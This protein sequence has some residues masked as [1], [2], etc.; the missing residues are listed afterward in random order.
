MLVLERTWGSVS[1]A[2]KNGPFGSRQ[3]MRI[4]DQ[5]NSAVHYLRKLRMSH[6][7]VGIDNVALVSSPRH[8]NVLAKLTNFAN[9]TVRD[10]DQGASNEDIYAFAVFTSNLFVDHH[11]NCVAFDDTIPKEQL[12]SAVSPN[13]LLMRVQFHAL[14][15]LLNYIVSPDAIGES[16][17]DNIFYDLHQVFQSYIPA[18]SDQGAIQHAPQ[19]GKERLL[20]PVPSRKVASRPSLRS[21]DSEHEPDSS[22]L[23]A[24]ANSVGT[25]FP[26]IL[27]LDNVEF[28]ERRFQ[29]RERGSDALTWQD[30]LQKDE[31]TRHL[32]EEPATIDL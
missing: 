22:L 32:V 14:A 7:A 13:I 2:L 9:A 15:D 20:Q 18:K 8:T 19:Y 28:P 30:W 25:P 27:N 16:E 11:S 23:S 6:G 12:F 3:A 5:V 10:N 17:V 24:N 29:E 21:A 31:E 4:A 26:S 1:R